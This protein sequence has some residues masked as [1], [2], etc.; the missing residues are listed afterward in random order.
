[1]YVLRLGVAEV[2]IAETYS[3]SLMGLPAV[4][5]RCIMDMGTFVG[6]DTGSITVLR[7]SILSLK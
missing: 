3:A 7:R 1:M 6:D 5:G 2:E 4:G